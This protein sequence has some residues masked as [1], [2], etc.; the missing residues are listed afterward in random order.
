MVRIVGKY[1]PLLHWQGSDP[2]PLALWPIALHCRGFSSCATTGN[3]SHWELTLF[4]KPVKAALAL[5][6]LKNSNLISRQDYIGKNLKVLCTLPSQ[7]ST[8]SNQN[9]SA[10]YRTFIGALWMQLR[11]IWFLSPLHQRHQWPTKVRIVIFHL[12]HFPGNSIKFWN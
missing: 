10:L 2:L 4:G 11:Y 7:G 8:L 9:V 1:A 5:P 3:H 6:S 12:Q